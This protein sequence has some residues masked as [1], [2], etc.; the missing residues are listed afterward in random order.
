V[1]HSYTHF[2]EVPELLAQR[3]VQWRL[4]H[5][6]FDIIELAR[7]TSHSL[8]HVSTTYWHVF[9]TL[10]LMWLW[11]A[12]GKLPRSDRWQ[13]QARSA[14]RDDLVA[15]LRDLAEDAVQANGVPEWQSANERLVGRT[16]TMFTE[17]RRVDTHDLTTLSVA[18]RQLRNLALLT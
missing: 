4:L 8:T 17:L 5:T 9:E 18:V 15:A 7:S 10:D 2:Q 11:E 3:S 13:T 12:V 16:M 1:Q 6:C 14:L